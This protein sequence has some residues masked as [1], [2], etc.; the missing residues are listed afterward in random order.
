MDEQLVAFKGRCGFVQYMPNKLV[1]F[2]IKIIMV[3]DVKYPY[4][5]NFEIY[6]GMQPEGPYRVSNKMN[7]PGT[8]TIRRHY[9]QEV[10]LELARPYIEHRI[11]MQNIPRSIKMK[12][13][14]LLG[15][16]EQPPQ[17]N[18]PI[19]GGVGRCYSCSRA[20]DRSTRKQCSKCMKR[21]CSDHQMSMLKF[22]EAQVVTL[23]RNHLQLLQVPPHPRNPVSLWCKRLYNKY[24]RKKKLWNIND[25][26]AQK[27]HYLI[28]EMIAIDK[29]P[30]SIVDHHEGFKRLLNNSLP[31]YTIPGRIYFT[32]TIIPDMYERVVRKLKNELEMAE[33]IAFTSDLWTS[34]VNNAAFLSFTGH[35]ISE[36]FK[37]NHA[38]LNMAHFPESHTS[39]NIK[40]EL[41]QCVT[42]WNI[43]VTKIQAIVHDNGANMVK[44]VKE[45]LFP[46]ERCFIHTL[47]LVLNNAL[48]KSSP[49]T[50]ILTCARR[51][52]THF[53]HSGY[54]KLESIQS[55]LGLPKHKLIQDI[56]TRWNS[57]YYLLERL[58][59]QKSNFGVYFRIKEREF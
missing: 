12:G 31:Q 19:R 38:V 26:R 44:G 48:S 41:L 50:E 54:T 23:P 14:Q 36:N 30:L 13:R 8:K 17:P 27:Y 59:E 9:L 51:I 45:T 18:L 56:Q 46:S 16:L 10:G 1:K 34:S 5:Y 25:S 35:W 49:I 39:E 6:Y 28:G 11:S 7:N 42:K 32:E 55:E 47:Q 20:R 2:G 4:V 58:L 57:T 15:L 33:A 29:E 52:V 40:I 37:L 22:M 3:V 24:L 43:S 21:I 53:N